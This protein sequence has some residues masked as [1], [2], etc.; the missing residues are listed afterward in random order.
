MIRPRSLVLCLLVQLAA[1]PA[2]AGMPIG[3]DPSRD[4][5]QYSH[6]VWT[7][8]DGLPQN[9]VGAIVQTP[10]GYLWFATLEGI[11]RFDGTSF[12]VFNARNTPPL[13]MNYTTSLLVARDSTMYIGTFGSGIL[14]C[15]KGGFRRVAGP[16]DIEHMQIHQFHEDRHGD[17][18]AASSGGLIQIKQDSIVKIHTVSDGLPHNVTTA[19]REDH[20]GRLLVAT[21]VGIW[22]REGDC[23]TPWMKGLEAK[24]IKGYGFDFALPLVLGAVPTDLC[25]GKD[26]VLW[27]G[28]RERGLFRYHEGRLDALGLPGPPSVGPIMR[29]FEDRR[30]TLWIG[31]AM[32]GLA[33]FRDGR[34]SRFTP[35]D[36]LS[37]DEVL[38][39]F[40]DREGNL[41]AGVST[42]GVNR[43][44]NSAF[45]TYRVGES[46]GDNM[47]WTIGED[48]GGRLIASSASGDMFTLEGKR[49]VR[50]TRFRLLTG[51]IATAYHRDRAGRLWVTSSKGLFLDD[52]TGVRH[53]DVGPSYGVAEDR[54]G[55]LWA[56]AAKGIHL[57]H[58][59]RLDRVDLDGSTLETQFNQV[60]Y[61]DREDVLWLVSRGR[62]VARVRVPAAGSASVRIHPSW[63]RWFPVNRGTVN[64]W[65]MT[66]APDAREG[67]WV[68]TT[69]AG[70]HYIRGDSVYS[71]GPAQGLPEDGLF[72]AMQDPRGW[73]WMSS[74]NGVHRVRVQ[75]L[76]DLFA[77]RRETVGFE[78]FGISDG[79]NSDECNGGFQSSGLQS[80]DG[81]LWF[82]TTAGIVM[83]DPRRMATN[84]VPPAVVIER[85]RVDNVEGPFPGGIEFPPGNGDLE[86]HFT[87]LS[88]DAPERVRYRYMLEGFNRNWVD[89]GNRNDA[90][91]TNLPPGSY[92]FRV[93]AANASGVWNDAGASYAFHLRPHFHQ[94][95]WF[96]LLMALGL[97]ALVVGGLFLYKRDRDRE[98]QASQLESQLAQ[99]QIQI[100]EMQLQPHFL[101]NTLNGI[102][103]LIKE[104][105]DSASRM[106]ARLSE[107]LRLTLD[108]AGMQEVPLRRELEFLDRYL[109]IE[110]LRFGERLQVEQH[111][112]TEL[113]DALVPN[114][115]LQPLVE[116]AIRHGVSKRRGPSLI[117][118]AVERTN[119]SLTI[120]VRDNGTG[121]K[122]ENG[123]AVKE[124]IG[125]RN[126]RQRLQH[127]YGNA[128]ECRLVSPPEGGV[129][130]VLTIPFHK[131]GN[132]V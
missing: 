3:L 36:G 44:T 38:S 109:Q 43:F 30:G 96:F 14:R 111:V 106:I 20:H 72:C 33:R 119:G 131:D 120:H 118:V 83:V 85:V 127:L 28:T 129:D 35:E 64:G 112:E 75:D 107:F 1:V 76:F 95:V 90:Y 68:T 63:V 7:K 67:V 105:P 45:T 40:E 46:V 80:A 32:G 29:L 9:S 125:L 84:T 77:G 91:Y 66:V 62:G 89:A 22:L 37:G 113:L 60:L 92:R 110:R 93:I 97:T 78:S 116:N 69:G 56:V 99:A 26:S 19:V 122:A 57:W 126:T 15:R 86:F 70:L 79:M 23:F 94:T 58:R 49:F 73:M 55:R 82:P 88:F 102:M 61:D 8:R 52:G 31:T 34:F 132:S 16:M 117:A 48:R 47:V 53:F 11:A 123:R 65:A 74:N 81:R 13:K 101:F 54:T 124:G 121:L 87:G 108:S 39:L 103:V 128:Q 104:D 17:I 12:R 24:S 42:A 71:L 25:V 114:L 130:V 6:R 98:L 50:D 2:H 10:D 18:W 100:L 4:I 115:I 27:I 51:K 59:G 21:P 5:S 41:W